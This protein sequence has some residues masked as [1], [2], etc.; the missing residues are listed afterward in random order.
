MYFYHFSSTPAARSANELDAIRTG[1]VARLGKF[2]IKRRFAGQ[3][4]PAAGCKNE[5]QKTKPGARESPGGAGGRLVEELGE[6][7]K[8]F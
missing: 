6:G 3:S 8:N 5:F 7:R 2:A 1:V 4:S